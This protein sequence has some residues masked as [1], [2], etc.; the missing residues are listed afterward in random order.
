MVDH[1]SGV[2]GASKPKTGGTANEG[3]GT[4]GSKEEG[5]GQY[6]GLTVFTAGGGEPV[7][8]GVYRVWTGEEVGVGHN[9]SEGWGVFTLKE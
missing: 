3:A 2:S 1:A 7:E 6:D 8:P 9:V 5:M 4:E